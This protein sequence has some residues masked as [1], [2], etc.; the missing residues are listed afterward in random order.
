MK[1]LSHVQLFVT[2]WTVAHTRLL[3][4]W[5]SPGKT[6]RSGLLFPPSGDLPDPGIEPRSPALQADTL[7]S[8]PPGKPLRTPSYR[9]CIFKPH[10]LHRAS[11]NPRPRLLVRAHCPQPHCV[12]AGALFLGREPGPNSSLRLP[13]PNGN[14]QQE[15]EA[16]VAQSGVSA[17]ESLRIEETTAVIL[18]KLT[19][20]PLAPGGMC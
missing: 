1:S 10:W 20:E 11:E 18:S 6:Y 5:D 15:Q 14:G 4:P 16:R 3:C 8:E 9:M 13:K 12:Y 2:P 7:S 17:F 19:L